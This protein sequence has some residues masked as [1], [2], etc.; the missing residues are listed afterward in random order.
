MLKKNQE[1]KQTKKI[2]LK[3]SRWMEKKYVKT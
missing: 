1:K 3:I 2:F